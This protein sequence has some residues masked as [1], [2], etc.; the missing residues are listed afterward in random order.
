MVGAV[1]EVEQR[2]STTA[3]SMRS[4][5]NTLYHVDAATVPVS[6]HPF[7]VPR[8]QLAVVLAKA[9]NCMRTRLLIVVASDEAAPAAMLTVVPDA[10]AGF[11]SVR[12]VKASACPT[13]EAIVV[14]VVPVSP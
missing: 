3:V 7:P 8:V 5:T 2:T 13:T 4:M 11:E 6:R 10:A 1:A 9:P 14:Q 12:P